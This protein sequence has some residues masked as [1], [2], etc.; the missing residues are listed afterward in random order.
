MKTHKDWFK[1]QYADISRE[2]LI[3]FL[4]ESGENLNTY[5]QAHN[6]LKNLD[7]QK[8]RTIKELELENKRL[9]GDGHVFLADISLMKS[10]EKKIEKL[11]KSLS[12]LSDW[13][14]DQV[15]D[16]ESAQKLNVSLYDEIEQLEGKIEALEHANEQLRNEVRLLIKAERQSAIQMA[17]LE[18]EYHRLAEAV[19]P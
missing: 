9:S 6:S 1:E 11:E 2:S 12:T 3:D 17:E 14:D 7:A 5:T 18:L 15:E 4:W 8:M 13:Y 16:N 10:Q 19:K